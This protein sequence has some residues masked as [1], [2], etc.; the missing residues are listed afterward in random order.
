MHPVSVAMAWLGDFVELLSRCPG[1]LAQLAGREEIVQLASGYDF[2]WNIS[3]TKP[4]TK[5]KRKR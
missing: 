1:G 4:K 5:R 2:K 3:K